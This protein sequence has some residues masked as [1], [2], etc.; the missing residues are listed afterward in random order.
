MAYLFSLVE[1]YAMWETHRMPSAEQPPPFALSP[2]LMRTTRSE[3]VESAKPAGAYEIK[4]LLP[5]ATVSQLLDS[6]QR[7]M[8]WDAYCDA[9][10]SDSPWPSY[11]LESLYLDT[12]IWSV[13][14]RLPG[15]GRRKFRVRRY[16]NADAIYLERKSKRKG[17]V[18]KTR[19]QIPL[20]HAS[21]L[22]VPT[23]DPASHSH[24]FQKRIQSRGLQ[25]VVRIGYRRCALMSTSEHGIVRL[26]VDVALRC[27][28]AVDY[29]FSD[30]ASDPWTS[31]LDGH[32]IVEFKYG[33]A[34]P[35]QFRSWI[36]AFGL[37]S[38]SCSKYRNAVAGLQL[39]PVQSDFTR[40]FQPEG[41]EEEA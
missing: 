10:P 37:N 20:Q 26:T 40:A 35:S 7:T 23:L 22:S 4:F 33:V 32:A 30:E 12:P 11:Q 36:D 27:K 13:Y 17:L 14:H 19:S 29:A 39:A 2:S 34:M 15:Y 31:I 8:H 5:L 25:P 9:S 16:G 18:R 6:A 28:R 21:Q 24:W 38:T 3:G 1:V 41:I